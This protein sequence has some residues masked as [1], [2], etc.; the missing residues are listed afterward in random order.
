MPGAGDWKSVGKRVRSW[1]PLFLNI[2][3][4]DLRWVLTCGAAFAK[5]YE[6]GL[7]RRGSAFL[8][9]HRWD[10]GSAWLGIQPTLNC[11]DLCIFP[12]IPLRGSYI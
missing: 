3:V 4:L 11:V 10:P 2:L 6:K 12:E 5:K 7:A 1:G 9:T 8:G